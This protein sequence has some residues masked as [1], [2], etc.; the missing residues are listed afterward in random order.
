[1]PRAPQVQRAVALCPTANNMQGRTSREA[2]FE[3]SQVDPQQ[4]S[5][6]LLACG[7]HRGHAACG[8][9]AGAKDILFADLVFCMRNDCRF[10]DRIKLLIWDQTGMVLVHKR[11]EGGKFV[12]P[13]VRDGVMRM[14]SAQFAAL[15]EGVDWRLVRPERARRPL[16][17]G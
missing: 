10:A 17:A 15:F 5:I 4:G 12:W 13:H 1:M 2:G 14:S 9:K 16:V 8:Q 7:H 3:R 6:R 11:L